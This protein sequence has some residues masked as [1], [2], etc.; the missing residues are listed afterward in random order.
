MIA[1]TTIA[2]AIRLL[3]HLGVVDDNAQVFELLLLMQ[4]FQLGQVATVDLTVT[5][6]IDSKVGHTIYNS[7]ISHNLGRHV[8]DN[9]VVVLLL[10]FLHQHIQTLAHQ[11]L[12][13]VGR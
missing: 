9:N 8:I 12:H 1:V 5:D 3:I 11:Q 6:Y 7:C 13:G 2:I 4:A 10:Q